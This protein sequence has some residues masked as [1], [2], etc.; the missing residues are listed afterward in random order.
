MDARRFDTVTKAFAHDTTRRRV[1]RGLVAG[2][3][4]GALIAGPATRQAAARGCK[5]IG[6]LCGRNRQCCGRKKGR[7]ICA[8]N[9]HPGASDHDQC[10]IA[11]GERCSSTDQC[12]GL[13]EVTCGG[14]PS[15]LRCGVFM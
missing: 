6:T 4:S 10:C 9:H 8:R 13:I 2:I 14:D 1:L 5:A 3:A 12:C 7:V 11:E 15:D